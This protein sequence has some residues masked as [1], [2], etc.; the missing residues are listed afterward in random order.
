VSYADFRV[1]LST[2]VT[3]PLIECKVTNVVRGSFTDIVF[4]LDGAHATA[5]FSSGPAPS[6]ST[7]T[8]GSD[9]SELAV[10]APETRPTGVMFLCF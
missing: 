7:L 10:M 6:P 9:T 4:D 5:H 3:S 1:F 2:S 8:V